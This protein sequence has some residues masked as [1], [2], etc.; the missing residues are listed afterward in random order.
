MLIDVPLIQTGI[1]VPRR[2]RQ[3]GPLMCA[4]VAD[5]EVM[6]KSLSYIFASEGPQARH[7]RLYQRTKRKHCEQA[8]QEK[9]KC[10]KPQQQNVITSENARRE[11]RDRLQ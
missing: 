4:T 6:A 9:N 7:E 5:I 2:E 10:A 8:R 3:S 1:I 11:L